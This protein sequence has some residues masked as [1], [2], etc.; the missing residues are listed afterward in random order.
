MVKAREDLGVGVDV[1]FWFYLGGDGELLRV[2]S[3][4]VMV[5]YLRFDRSILLRMDGSG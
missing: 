4:E 3:R 5:F 2:L 1:G